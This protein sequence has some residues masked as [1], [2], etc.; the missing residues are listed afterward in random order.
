MTPEQLPT[1]KVLVAGATKVGKTSLVNNLVFFNFFDVSPTIGVNF[2]QKTIIGEDGPLNLSIWDLSG[3]DR[4]RFLMPQFC[5]GAA[6]IVLV[7]DQT[8]PASLK[9]AGKWLKFISQ[10]ARPSYQSATVLAGTKADLP[11]TISSAKI[12]AFCSDYQIPEYFRCSAKT[13]ENVT[14]VFTAICTAIQRCTPEL[15]A[16]PNIIRS[17]QL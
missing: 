6:G 10:F 17:Y 4:F 5:R 9:I 2:A 8:R 13:G 3:Q 16:S 15:V 11:S 12:K 1:A 7:F 14:Q